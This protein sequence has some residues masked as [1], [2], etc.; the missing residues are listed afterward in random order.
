MILALIVHRPSFVVSP[1]SQC[2]CAPKPLDLPPLSSATEALSTIPTMRLFPVHL[3]H[4][5]HSRSIKTKISYH[6]PTSH[7]IPTD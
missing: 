7:P 3:S 6:F 4:A 5:E 1:S 2:L